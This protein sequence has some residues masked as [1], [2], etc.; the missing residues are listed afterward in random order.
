MKKRQALSVEMKV[1]VKFMPKNDDDELRKNLSYQHPSGPDL[2]RNLNTLCS[3]AFRWEMTVI[4]YISKHCTMSLCGGNP[5][6][7]K[8]GVMFLQSFQSCLLESVPSSL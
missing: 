1:A 2:F 7:V 8:V 6:R 3:Y 4:M 5:L